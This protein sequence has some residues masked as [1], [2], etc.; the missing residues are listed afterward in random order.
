[1]GR[2]WARSVG[3]MMYVWDWADAIN[4]ASA[5]AASTGTRQSVRWDAWMNAWRVAP[6]DRS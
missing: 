6:L 4:L 3:R 1:M 5:R 2:G